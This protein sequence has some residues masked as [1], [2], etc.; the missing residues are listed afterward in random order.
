MQ[1]T[2]YKTQKI[3]SS[4]SFKDQISSPETGLKTSRD[5]VRPQGSLEYYLQI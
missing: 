3:S 1:I 2:N 4:I 5:V